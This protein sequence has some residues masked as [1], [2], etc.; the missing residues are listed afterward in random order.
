M[1]PTDQA[2]RLA[3]LPD[4]WPEISQHLDASATRAAKSAAWFALDLGGISS[5]DMRAAMHAKFRKGEAEHGRD[6]LRMTREDIRHEIKNEH[7]DL[8]I[9][10]AMLATR[11]PDPVLSVADFVTNADPGDEQAA[12]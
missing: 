6:W 3:T 1:H 10:Y 4:L 9:Y 2:D 8:V 11:W 7:I 5:A 12:A